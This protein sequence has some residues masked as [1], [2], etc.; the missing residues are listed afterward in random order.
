MFDADKDGR[1]GKDEAPDRMKQRWAQIDGNGDGFATLEELE[2]REN[3]RFPEAGESAQQSESG[4]RPA[5]GGTRGSGHQPAGTFSV[6]TL[7]TGSPRFDT[8]RSGPATMIQANGKYYLIDM[9]NGTQSRLNELGVTP[10]QIEGLLLT[11]HHLDHNEDLIP[12]FINTR[13]MG[14]KPPVIGT[15]GTR[16]Y[17][18][19]IMSSYAEDISYRLGRKGLTIQEFQPLDVRE[20]KGGESFALGGMK[21]TTARVNHTIHTVAYRFDSGGRSIVISGDL[22]YSDSLVQLARGA[23]VLVI[24]SGSLIVRK[25]VASRPGP[26]A[27]QNGHGSGGDKP[28]GAKAHASAEDVATMAAKAG[29][30]KLVLTHIAPGEV[31][32]EATIKAARPIYQGEVIVAHDLLEVAAAGA[33][34]QG[35]ASTGSQRVFVKAGIPAARADGKSWATAFPTVQ[36]GLDAAEKQGGGE[37]WVAAGTYTPTTTADRT[38]SFRLRDGVGLLGGFAGTESQV[39]QRDFNKNP[40]ILSGDI[41]R[42]GFMED[43]CYSVVTG[44]DRAVLDGFTITGGYSL[45]A[46]G[47]PGAPPAGGGPPPSAGGGAPIHITP[48][49]VLS[50]PGKGSGAGMMI[51]Q[52]APIVRDCVFRDNQGGKG[53]AVYNMCATSFP[54][55][56]DVPIAA[57][58]FI[59]CTFLANHA[60]G[61][62]GAV[63][64]DMGIGPIFT[65]CL[66]KENTC[67]GKGGAM[68]NDFGCSPVLANCLFTGNRADGGG[69][70][71]NDGGSSPLIIHC[72]F[73]GNA[74]V[75][76]GAAL[77]QGT[78]PA[79]NPIITA[80]IIWGNLCENGPAGIY[81]WHDNSP[82]VTASCIEGGWPGKGNVNSDPAFIDPAKGIFKPRPESPCAAMGYTVETP[83]DLLK[84]APRTFTPP[85]PPAPARLRPTAAKPVLRVDSRAMTGKHDGSSWPNAFQSL[86]DALVA[87]TES[88]AEIWVAAGVYHP[89]MGT[90]RSAA[91]VIPF[92]TEIYGGFSGRE[93]SRDA[94]QPD[95]HVTQLSGDIGRKDDASD[96]SYHVVIGADASL[97]DGFIIRDGNADGTTYDAKGGGMINY[98]RGPQVGPMGAATGVSP[99]VRDCKFQ[100]NHAIEGG[101]VYN[102]DR[103]TPEFANCVFVENSADYGGA[104]VDRVGV[105]SSLKDCVFE[106][107]RARWRAGAVL[108]DYGARP[109]F[110]SCRF[111]GNQSACHG[112]AVAMV[113]RASQLE[114]TITHFIRCEFTGNSAIKQGGAIHAADSA[115]AGLDHCGLNQNTAGTGGGAITVVTRAKLVVLESTMDGTALVKGN[116][117][118]IVSGNG[119]I[120]TNKLDWPDQGNPQATTGFRPPAGFPPAAR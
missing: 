32:E 120:S 38:Q 119:I 10:R 54:P 79:N 60:R 105:R 115:V 51:Y 37:V 41:G 63:A 108:L 43:N 61:R 18:D 42:A 52:C 14:A 111:T 100:A 21:V 22:S 56:P 44:A 23:D 27:G 104:M 113:S 50:G 35:A 49:T 1:I 70:L 71:G 19:F 82:Q 7:G 65:G 59:R 2:A 106:N 55:K 53:G 3:R 97:I 88:P 94:R 73:T 107:N 40:T 101:A 31:D 46:G 114:N 8:A 66:F 93:S 110:T 77:Y 84:V 39:S 15:P 118:M 17:I 64:N 92:G 116:P 24:D 16:S 87:A 20:V 75:Q 33:T 30:K 96:N 62:G 78:G 117:G 112:G 95:K 48:Q 58:S 74:A 36:A 80:C 11:H 13:L 85:S 102:Y 29:V 98:H 81:N 89:T 57:P 109:V 26:P 25:G 103:G 5:D 9:G 45:N 68:Y 69:A 76:E 28:E 86:A 4:G 47:F 99:K 6:I 12:M 67:D 34:A 91:F 90:D 72:T 83:P